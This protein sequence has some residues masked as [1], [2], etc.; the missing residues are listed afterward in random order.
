MAAEGTSQTDPL[1]GVDFH[2]CHS[3][4]WEPRG[5]YIIPEH[6]DFGRFGDTQDHVVL[7]GHTH[8]P[9]DDERDGVRYVNPGSIGPRRFKHPISFAFLEPDG[10]VTFRTVDP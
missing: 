9:A 8:M 10:G 7:Y 1:D 6:Q 2:L 4:P 3:T 5:A